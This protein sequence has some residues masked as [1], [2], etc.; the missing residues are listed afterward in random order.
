MQL[1]HRSQRGDTIIEVVVAFAIFATMAAGA[2]AVMNKGIATAMRSFEI[3]QVR[4]EIDSQAEVLRYANAEYINRFTRGATPPDGIWT[5]IKN[6]FSGL[7]AAQ[8]AE[9][10]SITSDGSCPD[11]N[12][13][14]EAFIVDPV[15]NT[16]YGG[17]SHID[18]GK[19]ETAVPFPKV[20]YNATVGD[21]GSAVG[22][23]IWIQALRNEGNSTT[24][25]VDF[26][27]RACWVGSGSTRPVTMGTTVRLYE[28]K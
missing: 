27:I 28:P 24:A 18:M 21:G 1:V 9:F 4:Q 25:Y 11:L 19:G 6:N 7:S 5:A 15:R 23:N 20:D 14:P 2:I 26:F 13:I 17:V 16:A 12:Q 10:N 8:I 22:H 3:T